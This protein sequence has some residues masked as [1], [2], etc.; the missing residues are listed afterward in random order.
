MMEK[1]K[2]KI[3]LEVGKS[4]KNQHGNIEHIVD[5]V[6]GLSPFK[7]SSG[8]VYTEDG[9]FDRYSESDL[10][11]IEDVTDIKTI[12]TDDTTTTTDSKGVY[13]I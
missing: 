2:T 7:A 8:Y 11:L 12:T 6:W 3:K 4:Y 13:V 5:Y 10:D 9:R 1:G